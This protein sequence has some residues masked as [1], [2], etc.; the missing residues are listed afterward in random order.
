MTEQEPE[1]H[2]EQLRLARI[3]FVLPEPI[4]LPDGYQVVMATGDEGA[5]GFR[6]D[7]PQV[8]LIF[9]QVNTTQGR[10][11]AAMEAKWKAT[12]RAAGLP[13]RSEDPMDLE[14]D[15]EWTVVEALTPWDS[16]DP[17]LEGDVEHAAHWTPRTDVFARC[18]YA[19]RQV[20]RSYRQATETPYGLPTYARAISPVLVYSAGGLRETATV[21]GEAVML[22]R[23]TQD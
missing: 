7:D 8:S 5:S 2:T 21:D 14:L 4:S 20:V 11:T 12:S 6:P 3:F 13:P 18:L 22:I 23:P 19:A 17:I 16:P 10:T 1:L 9:H 15:I